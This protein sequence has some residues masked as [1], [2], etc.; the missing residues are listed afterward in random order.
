[1]RNDILKTLF[2][3]A[4]IVGAALAINL[5][6]GGKA[7]QAEVG[8][9]GEVILIPVGNGAAAWV[10]SPRDG[11]EYCYIDGSRMRCIAR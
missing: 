4:A 6:G 5:I 3:A 10:H 1:M 9:A 2:T 11:L 7:T 8:A